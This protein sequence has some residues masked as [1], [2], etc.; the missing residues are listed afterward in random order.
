MRSSISPVLISA[1]PLALAIGVFG[2]IFGAASTPLIGL[3]LTLAASLIVFSGAL[4]FAMVG[5]LLAGAPV[6]SLLVTAALL[7]LRHLLLGAALRARISG[8]VLKRAGLAWFLIDESVALTLA[9]RGWPAMTLVGSG[10]LFYIVWF[11]GTLIGTLGASLPQFGAVAEAIFPVL[12]V[13]LASISADRRDLKVRA[14]AAAALSAVLILIWP[15][16]RGFVPV[17]AVLLVIIPDVNP[18]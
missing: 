14:L 6:P 15:A 18:S 8:S 7:N 16:V 4:Q 2:T 9:A 3:E 12:F 17:V 11:V 1:I 13:G 10:L 5:L